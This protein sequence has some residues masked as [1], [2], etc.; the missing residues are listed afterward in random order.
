MTACGTPCWTAPEVLRNDRYTEKADIY[1]FGI[2]LWEFV[3]REDPFNGQPPFQV[4]ISVANE[5]LRPEMNDSFSP[6]F[7]DLTIACWAE[8]PDRRPSFEEIR[9]VLE[10]M[11]LDIPASPT[12]RRRDL[13]E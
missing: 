7:Y 11:G 5:G 12:P 13:V 2:C 4:V 8:D 10:N 1:S 3:T 6:E 9:I